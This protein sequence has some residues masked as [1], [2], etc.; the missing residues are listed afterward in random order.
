[1]ET[2]VQLPIQLH[3]VVPP[4]PEQRVMRD[5]RPP[6]PGSKPNRYHLPTRL[7]SSSPVG[8]RFRLPLSAEE[9]NQAAALLSF[10]R[11]T[12]FR[13]GAK[14]PGEQELFEESALGVLSSRQSTNYRG[15]RQ[16]TLGPK[17]AASLEGLLARLQRREA[18]PL[19]HATH[20]HLILG[21][22]YR[23]PF[24]QLL[25]FIGHKPVKS[26]ITVPQRIWD[27][28]R[29][30]AVDI[31]TIGYLPH[32]HVGILAEAL[33]RAALVASAGT[34]G[35]LVLMAPFAS[36]DSRKANASVI[37]EIE[38]IAGLSPAERNEGWGLQLV[39]Q[40]GELP[41]PLPLGPGLARKLGAN[42]LALRSERI[43]PGVNAEEKAPP[44][45]QVRQDMDI[46]E[47]VA[48]MTGRAAY[49]A[50]CH[51]TG[52]PRETAKRLLILERVDVLTPGGK[53]RLRQIRGELSDITDRLVENLPLWADL[54]TGRALSRN[55]AR[56]RKAFALAGQ[57]IYVGGL[58]RAEVEAA[59]LSW[60]GAIRAAG[61]AAAR[62][63]LTAELA[64][65][66]DL[67]AD[68]DLLSGTCIMAGPVNQNDIGK[69]FFGYPDLLAAAHPG[70][71]PTSL[72]VWTLK[73]K[74]IADPI[75]N[76]EQLLSAERKG[77][78]VDLRAGPHELVRIRG[79]DG[80]LRP[81]RQE[82]SRV[83]TERAYADQDNLLK[84]SGGEEI[85]GNAGERWSPGG[86]ATL[87]TP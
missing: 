57:R 16:I 3:P 49:N 38:A 12:T 1:M 77:A 56:G 84:G 46:P 22:P 25:T 78:L 47:E 81:M 61:A 29:N 64:G 11:P 33:E 20:A 83:N 72:L 59:G 74:T 28:W 27:K 36:P 2:T 42:L 44:G 4:P 76:E 30:G 75:G 31:P 8:F 37:A 10:P 67:P 15:F 6:G 85:A 17:D 58:D 50:L 66:I 73:A 45:Y 68:C 82:G 63:A 52:L 41:E 13:A 35:A 80:Q 26:L 21:L 70:R 79:N 24:T 7:Q 51:W 71:N 62:S 55:A 14:P 9:A 87:W 86:N 19:R 5:C 18:E 69:Q 34:R 39:A 48:V 40:V 54:P 60:E 65:L 53:G 23:T 32:L 43:Q